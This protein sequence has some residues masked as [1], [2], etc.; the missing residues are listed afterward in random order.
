MVILST[1]GKEEEEDEDGTG[2]CALAS[3]AGKGILPQLN[4]AVHHSKRRQKHPAL[5][6]EEER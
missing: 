6:P 1:S 2:E 4:L 5:T 3:K